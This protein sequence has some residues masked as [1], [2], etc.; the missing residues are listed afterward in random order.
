MSGF[1]V[2]PATGVPYI[3]F[4]GTDQINVKLTLSNIQ[5]LYAHPLDIRTILKQS[6]MLILKLIRGN[7]KI[8]LQRIC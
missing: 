2:D 4:H 8:A 7:I 6:W 5:L 3:S 1:G